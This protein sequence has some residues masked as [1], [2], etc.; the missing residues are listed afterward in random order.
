[1]NIINVNAQKQRILTNDAD[2]SAE[3]VKSFEYWKDNA[4]DVLVFTFIFLSSNP[5]GLYFVFHHFRI[6][7]IM[8]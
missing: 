8:Y 2:D 5:A 4:C 3:K 1:M 6:D 7:S